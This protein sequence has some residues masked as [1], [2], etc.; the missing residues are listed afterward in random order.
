[1]GDWGHIGIDWGLSVFVS[2][3]GR[4]SMRKGCCGT[5]GKSVE[6][7]RVMADSSRCLCWWGVVL[8]VGEQ[9]GNFMVANPEILRLFVRGKSASHPVSL[10]GTVFRLP[11]GAPQYSMVSC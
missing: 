5:G 7:S 11:A 4:V 1:M 2:C 10:T 3:I 6:I 9:H 8:V